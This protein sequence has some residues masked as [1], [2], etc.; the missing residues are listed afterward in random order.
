MIKRALISVFDKSGISEL[1]KSLDEMGIEII[2]TG[3]T[4]KLLKQEGIRVTSVEEVTGFPEVLDGRVKTLH[5]KIFAGILSD[6]ENKNHAEEIEKL[7]VKCVDLVVVNLYPFKETVSGSPSLKDAIEQ[8]DIGGVTLIRAAAKNF[9]N[10]YVLVSPDEYKGFISKL[11]QSKNNI[12]HE[13]S[14]KL[15]TDAFSVVTS[16]DNE[17]TKYFRS[18][19]KVNEKPEDTGLLILDERKARSLRYGENPHQKGLLIKE[20]FDDVFEVLH[21]KDLSYNNILDIDSAF[22]LISEFEHD[23]PACAII[24]HGNPSG[25]AVSSDLKN[26]YK[27]AY[28]T[29]TVSP[30]GGIVIFNKKLDFKTSIDIDKLFTEIILA[31][32]FDDEA[33]E[34]LMKKKNR[35]L[36]TFKFAESRFEFRKVTGGVLYQEKDNRSLRKDELRVVT[37]RKPS[38][39]EIE[40][41]LFAFKIVKH[42]KSNAIVFVKNKRTLAI[43]GGQPSRIDSTKIAVAKA[44]EF[45]NSL[46]KS[47]AASDAFFPFP[48]GLIEIAKAG[49]AAVIQPG[50][51]VKDEEVIKAAD[52]LNIAMVFTGIRH[53]R[54]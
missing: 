27:R 21:G 40:D 53:F 23:D 43:G 31:P 4:Y 15:A 41:L 1:A 14:L 37:N 25:A 32:G 6:R 34:L 48:D 12:D 11:V 5:P 29:D 49:A 22:S 9:Q 10:V 51:S 42:T 24:K 50:G 39:D 20:D 52:D 38:D 19:G 7:D 18:I 44:R 16:Y 35:R 46:E 2:S 33:L 13:Y 17:I 28:E 36:V 3:G 8:I 54:H 47:V 26:A 30:F 45:G